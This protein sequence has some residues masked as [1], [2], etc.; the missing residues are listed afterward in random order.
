MRTEEFKAV[1]GENELIPRGLD[2]YL[3]EE[4]RKLDKRVVVAPGIIYHHLP[5]DN[6]DKLLR[7][8]SRNGRQ[9]AFSNRYFP[10]WVI[11][12]PSKHG[13]FKAHM[14][15]SLRILRFPVGL[16]RSLMTGKFVWFLCEVAYA[17]GFTYEWF[18]AKESLEQST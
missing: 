17:L 7:Q 15:F 14:P 4:F 18:F 3:R 13:P 6:L 2:P 9:A 10:Q 16:L 1:G 5:P 8:F 11:E 12:T